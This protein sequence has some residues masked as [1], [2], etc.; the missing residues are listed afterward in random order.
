[1]PSR[2]RALRFE[3]PFRR[4]LTRNV[5]IAAVVGVVLAF[6]R[7]DLGLFLPVTILALW[8]S[9][10]GHYVELLFLNGV[11]PRVPQGRATQAVARLLVW[12]LGGAIL[13]VCTA[14]TARALP[15]AGPPLT[16]WWFGSVLFIGLELAVHGIFV[17]RG[18]PNFYDGRG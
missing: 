14:V 7:H 6:R 13:Y 2:D 8:F 1:M 16:Q 17:L 10:G 3:E 11:R 4:T 12:F 9:L 15:I 18:L 5:T